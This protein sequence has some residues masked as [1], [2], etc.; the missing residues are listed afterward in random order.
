MTSSDDS[1]LTL[2]SVTKTFP[3]G[4][5]GPF[6]RGLKTVAVDD[7]S[8]E[9]YERDT[10]SLVGESGC[11]KST[12]SRLLLGLET[13]DHGAV[14]FGGREI[15]SLDRRGRQRFRADV[16]AVFQDPAS[17][18]NPRHRVRDIVA[19]PLIAS[20]TSAREASRRRVD[21]LL[22]E[23]GLGPEHARRF[24]HELSGGQR[25]RVMIARALA[26]SPRIIILD[27]PVSS[28]DVSV[29]AQIINLLSAV[30]DSHGVGYLLI[31]H[32]LATVRSFSDRVAV[33][34]LGRIVEAGEVGV[35]FTRPAHP[36]TVGLLSAAL[37]TSRVKE[38]IIL[39]PEVT[40]ATAGCTFRSRCWLYATL[41]E[42]ERCRIDRPPLQHVDG[43]HDAACHFSDMVSDRASEVV[44]ALNARN[45]QI[46]TDSRGASIEEKGV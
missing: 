12:T 44:G 13:P 38:Q 6:N 30:R 28:L 31:S 40:R 19:E 22:S 24:P 46:H 42:P 3:T 21:G 33:I 18:M 7:L 14:K 15:G 17:A 16:Q 9:L 34:Y 35:I 23:V 45:N 11:G 5:A 4:P 32:D 1:I 8:L 26:P 29:R 39:T 25:Q 20:H 10:L 36:Y 43:R 2:D 37:P 27:E 41:G